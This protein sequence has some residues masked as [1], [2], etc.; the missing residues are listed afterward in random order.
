MSYTLN[1]KIDEKSLSV[2]NASGYKLCFCRGTAQ[3]AG[4][5][6]PYPMIWMSVR[7]FEDNA[8]TWDQNSYQNFSSASSISAGAVVTSLS[9]TDS[10]M[11]TTKM[12]TFQNSVFT[13]AGD[14]SA[15]GYVWR[16]DTRA[17]RKTLVWA[18]HP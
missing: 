7:A 13:Q 11:D 9:E 5:T 16:A 14:L 15:P 10:P 17:G 1:C 3:G 18:G 8:I 2:L 4:T 12:Y 6:Q